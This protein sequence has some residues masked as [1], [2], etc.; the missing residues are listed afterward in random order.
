MV[1]LAFLVLIIGAS[2]SPRPYRSITQSEIFSQNHTGFYLFDPL[3]EKVLIDVNGSKYFTPASNTKIFTF[4]TSLLM[5]GDS[6]PGL[7]YVETGD[8]LIVW[9]T[10]D[11][12]FLNPDLPESKVFDFLRF[13]EKQL[14][15]SVENFYDTPFG[16]GWAWD[17]YNYEY[18]PEKSPLPVYGNMIQIKGDKDSMIIIPPFFEKMMVPEQKESTYFK[19]D[20]HSN[21]IYYYVTETATL[22]RKIPFLT[23]HKLLVDMLE[24]TLSRSVVLINKKLPSDAGTIYSVPSDSV[25]KR[26]MQVSD[27]FIAEQLM[28]MNGGGGG[29]LLNDS[30]N[31]EQSINYSRDSLL[32]DLP[33][34]LIWRDGSGLSRYNL[35]TPRTIVA[36]WGKIAEL[37]PKD[38]LY[39]L[40]A[41]G[42]VSGTIENWYRAESPYIYGKTG[43]LSNN[44]CLSGF[45]ETKSGKTLIFS[46]MNNNYRY[47]S[48]T[49]KV[50][51]E[52]ILREIYEKY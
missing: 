41:E 49:I 40:I 50:E 22:D 15:V 48:G 33:D 20:L 39:Q 35:F 29:G 9:G 25:Y 24:D 19:R 30:L 16:A 28:L 8:S 32:S 31:T 21:L 45:I 43:T 13:S 52:R 4:Y 3:N 10:G 38:R 42:G 37:V 26:M 36:L 11:P 23:S 44:H 17:D 2:C 47:G 27:N 46:F 1:R 14:F 18:Q 12:S 7:H 34:P 6:L 5:L 51:M